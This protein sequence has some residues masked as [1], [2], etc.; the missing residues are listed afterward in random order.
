MLKGR[1]LESGWEFTK[2]LTQI[3]SIF[4]NFGP[5]NLEIIMTKSSF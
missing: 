3:L 5:L 4:C 1:K 2:L